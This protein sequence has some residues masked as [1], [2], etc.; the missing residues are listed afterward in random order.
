MVLAWPGASSR[1]GVSRLPG[2]A[3]FL[4]GPVLPRPRA[5]FALRAEGRRRLTQLPRREDYA[6]GDTTE[7]RLRFHP[8]RFKDG[9]VARA[10]ETAEA[11]PTWRVR[12]LP[13]R[14]HVVAVVGEEKEPE[15]QWQLRPPPALRVLLTAGACGKE[16]F[17]RLIRQSGRD[18]DRL[19]TEP[20]PEVEPVGAL[21]CGAVAVLLL[22]PGKAA[23]GLLRS[24]ERQAA[25]KRQPKGWELQE[26]KVIS[27]YAVRGKEK[28][29]TGRFQLFEDAKKRGHGG[30]SAGAKLR[31]HNAKRFFE[32]INS[33]FDEWG[34]ELRRLWREDPETE[35][36]V[37]GWPPTAVFFAG[38][39]RLRRMLL[40]CKN[41][42]CPLPSDTKLWIKVP[43]PFSEADPSLE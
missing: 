3:G 36:A 9:S 16:Q 25:S 27:T 20:S 13:R 8:V 34:L 14:G 41:P 43:A 35:G 2:T 15:V 17:L 30:R 11:T 12:V 22:G 10:L 28:K 37:R 19:E 33:K 23:L 5:L 29:G 40:D 26:H 32:K 4:T 18:Q 39:L 42:K 38:D 1:C 7:K 6:P 24:L 31:R 21:C